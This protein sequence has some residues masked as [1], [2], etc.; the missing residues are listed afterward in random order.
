MS[1]SQKSK[2][3]SASTKSGQTRAA[4]EKLS[5][6][7]TKTNVSGTAPARPPEKPGTSDTKDHDYI[8]AGTFIAVT[9]NT[10]DKFQQVI[11][12]ILTAIAHDEANADNES[13]LAWF[14]GL[15]HATHKLDEDTSFRTITKIFKNITD[16]QGYRKFVLSFPRIQDYID[17]RNGS[18]T[19]GGFDFR[20]KASTQV[21]NQDAL[22]DAKLSTNPNPEV[23][24]S[25]EISS[26][27]D[28]GFMMCCGT[29]QDFTVLMTQMWVIMHRHCVAAPDDCVSRKWFE[30]EKQGILPY[31]TYQQA[32]VIMG[33]DSLFELYCYIRDCPPIISQL[34]VKWDNKILFRLKHDF[35][36]NST[37]SPASIQSGS[38][39]TLN[40]ADSFTLI[41]ETALISPVTPV[42]TNTTSGDTSLTP[43]MVSVARMPTKVHELRG[44]QREFY[45]I[46][47]NEI[48]T[49]TEFVVFHCFIFDLIQQ[50]CSA[51]HGRTDLIITN[52][53]RWTY[54]GLTRYKTFPAVQHIM[55]IDS[56][57]AYMKV[58][59]DYPPVLATISWDWQDVNLRYC[60]MLEPN[61]AQATI[62]QHHNLD[63]TKLNNTRSELLMF[64]SRFDTSI[65]EFHNRLTDMD[66]R[67]DCL[68]TRITAQ[69]SNIKWQ[70]Q[71][72][73]DDHKITLRNLADEQV[74]SYVATL[75]G[76]QDRDTAAHRT[77]L[78]VLTSTATQGFKDALAIILQEYMTSAKAVMADLSR[79]VQDALLAHTALASKTSLTG[80]SATGLEPSVLP[81]ATAN[82]TSAS[83][84][85]VPTSSQVHTSLPTSRFPNVDPAYK[86]HLLNVTFHNPYR[87]TDKEEAPLTSDTPMAPHPVTVATSFAPA[88]TLRDPTI[89]YPGV[90]RTTELPPVVNDSNVKNLTGVHP[91]SGYT[92]APMALPPLLYDYIMKRATIQFTGQNDILVF[93]NQLK[94]S[95]GHYGLYLIDVLD[96][97]LDKSLCPEVVESIRV[98]DD[99]YKAMAGC[100]YQKL[101]SYDTIPA[102]F[103]AARNIVNRFAEVNDGYKVLYAL[104]EP[105]LHR[106]V[107]STPPLE[108]HW[109]GIHEYAIK[110]QSYLNGEAIAGRNYTQKEQAGLFLN[111]LSAQYRP[112]IRKARLMLDMHGPTNHSVPDVLKLSALPST[113]ERWHEEETGQS[114]V[115]VAYKS[116]RETNTTDRRN[117]NNGTHGP[118]YQPQ[119]N[120]QRNVPTTDQKCSVCGAYGHNKTQCH[121]FAKYL[122]CKQADSRTDDAAKTKL[123]ESYKFEV[124]Q[125]AES[126]RKRQQMGTVRQLWNEGHSYEEIED[127]L[128][129]TLTGFDDLASIGSSAS[130][131]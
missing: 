122:L 102:E 103:T 131:E 121:P 12:P 16:L 61:G 51:N 86:E 64:S 9:L 66:Q 71:R 90:L 104:I 49:S 42:R 101:A 46:N 29:N 117:K 60:F 105:L 78:Q 50:W 112:A 109:N 93:Y 91:N 70:G 10:F 63:Q 80:A 39:T 95:V 99:R 6:S 67:L 30:W 27:A 45:I 3:A 56:L 81:V 40:D 24:D 82:A 41:D 94:H 79:E 116:D 83:E 111:G 125:K 128:L 62:L 113:I 14:E 85:Q 126:R 98:T 76:A 69:S 32:K 107:I 68:D 34:D 2:S 48:N 130:D 1:S 35:Q 20:V 73:L 65:Q 5:S 55:G 92:P 18:H 120:R 129:Q 31:T 53:R 74:T 15:H 33:I 38:D 119:D 114:I 89:V 26:F 4:A 84:N 7:S 59:Q 72:V 108:E 52:W 8:N 127:S 21:L 11:Y 123:I 19:M 77:Q 54:K 44:D 124:K 17:T 87:T 96:F 47:T 25:T 106:D 97:A 22:M 88:S 37:P 100:L 13:V 36:D 57:A 58:I 28:D 75:T 23:V 118:R 43:Q 110:V 115:R